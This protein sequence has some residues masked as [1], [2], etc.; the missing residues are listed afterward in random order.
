[1]KTRAE[2]EENQM[3]QYNREQDEI[4]HMK[5]YIARFGHGSAKLA[6]Q[7]KSKEK[8]LAKMQ[9]EGLTEKVVADKV[10][11]L[12]FAS[13]GHL[14]PPVLQFNKVSFGYSPDKIIY[15]DLD[16]GMDLDSRIALVGPNG[17]GKSTLLKL[18]A[19]ALVPTDGNIRRHAHL[20]VGWYHQHLTDQLDLNLSPLT[21]MMNCF[22]N[23]KEEETMRRAIGRFG[24]TGKTQTTPMKN[25]SDGQKSR[26][27]FAWL[28]F[29]EPHLLLLDEPT[30]HLDI[31]TIDSLAAAIN[32][33]EGAMVLVS[34]DFRLILQVAKE[35]WVCEHNS[36]VKW[37]GD[38][39]GY[40]QLLRKRMKLE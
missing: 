4:A 19:D 17:A 29:N 16:F 18:I 10:I 33:F 38:I 24:I 15:R 30:N 12:Q 20:K 22:P 34:H 2:K 35:I 21:Y 31:E 6:R 14:P 25:L 23:T 28:A 13:C 39:Q 5:D 9:A 32:S 27:C 8:T 26:V 11:K 7:A 37:K 36:V 40:K 1:M 3:K